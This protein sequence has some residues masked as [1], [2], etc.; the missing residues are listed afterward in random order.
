MTRREREEIYDDEQERIHREVRIIEEEDEE[1][2]YEEDGEQDEIENED[3]DEDEPFADSN[4]AEHTE[5]QIENGWM[6]ITTGRI[7]TDGA[8]PYYRYFIAIAI[9]CFISI[10]LTFVSLNA[11]REYRQREKYASVLHERSVLKEEER[12]GLS[13]KSEVT[14]RLES[15]GIKLVDLSKESRLITNEK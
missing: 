6:L 15:Y 13:S 7:L 1:R 3:E 4:A 2:D 14:Q 8:L 11:T 9:M 12:Y 10:V 5:Q